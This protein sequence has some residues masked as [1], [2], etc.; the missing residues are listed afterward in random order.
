MEL[1]LIQNA[2]GSDLRDM[3]AK[4]GEGAYHLW[5]HR[6]WNVHRG[7]VF[8]EQREPFASSQEVE[9]RLRS[10]V[11][12]E[13]P[14]GWTWLRGFAFGACVKAP[15]L[16][17][18]GEKLEQIIDIRNRIKGVF[19][20]LVYHSASPSVAFGIH[21]WT[22]GYLSPTYRRILEAIRE[23]GTECQGFVRDK[24]LFFEFTQK[25]AR[26]RMEEFKDEG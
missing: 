15:S 2:I 25:M 26:A 18:D 8:L 12:D 11:R 9:D 13:F 10:V 17:T 22:E 3:R 19:Q 7:V 24:G 20:W 5:E 16:P 4:S 23:G 14:L 1:E 21:T 6:T